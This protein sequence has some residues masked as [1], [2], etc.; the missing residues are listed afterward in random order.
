MLSLEE[1]YERI[2]DQEKER[3][4]VVTDSTRDDNPIVYV[5]DAFLRL[6]GYAAEEVQGR[7]CRF[8]Q[9]SDSDPKTVKAIH[10]ALDEVREITVDILNYRK[11]GSA[12]WNRLR[13]RPTYSQTGEHDGFVGLQNPISSSEVRAKPIYRFQE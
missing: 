12:F 3:S 4:L 5:N 10:E 1:A 11:D 13:M 6:T 2:T 8:L 9:G 7:N